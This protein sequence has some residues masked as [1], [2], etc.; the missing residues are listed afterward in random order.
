LHIHLSETP[1][2]DDAA[3]LVLGHLRHITGRVHKIAEDVDTIKL[4]MQS[5]GERLVSL[6]RGVVNVHSDL[7]LVNVR[8]ERLDNRLDRVERRLELRDELT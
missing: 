6:A 2:A 8:L 3:N 5:F 1:V 7:A 4:C